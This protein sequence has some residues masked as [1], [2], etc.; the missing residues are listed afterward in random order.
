M[1]D[2]ARRALNELERARAEVQPT[3]GVVTGIVTVGLL[4]SIS[5]LLAEPLVRLV[6]GPIVP[7]R[8][9]RRRRTRSSCP[10]PGMRCAA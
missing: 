10:R 3:P 2:R 4:E 5:D 9:R 6:F 8:S 7:S 1:M